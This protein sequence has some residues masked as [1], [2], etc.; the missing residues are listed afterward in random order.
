[1]NVKVHAALLEE[2]PTAAWA[3]AE[4][5]N[6]LFWFDDSIDERDSDADAYHVDGYDD[7][8]DHHALA[9]LA[10]KFHCKRGAAS[11]ADSTRSLSTATRLRAWNR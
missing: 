5:L 4:G 11:G 10:R 9:A 8:F 7:C 2:P 3:D 6:A 1:M